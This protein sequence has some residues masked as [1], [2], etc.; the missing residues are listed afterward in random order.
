MS[1]IDAATNTPWLITPD[2]L[3]VVLDAIQRES[4][5]PEL[6]RAIREDRAA[7]PSALALRSARPL[8]GARDVGMVG[9]VAVI[10]IVGPIVRRGDMFSE[11]SG[12]TALQGIATDVQAALA[13]PQVDA[14]LLSIDSPGG[15]VTGVSELATHILASRAAKPIWAYV[16]GMGASAAYWIGSA[17]ERVVLADTAAVGSIGVVLAVRDPAAG[18]ASSIEFV[19]SQSPRKRPN[20]TTEAGRQ[21]LQDLV[22]HTAEVFVSAVAAQRG[23]SEATVLADFGQGGVMVGRRAVEAGLADA[24]ST[25]DQTLTDLAQAA[26]ARRRQPYTGRSV[27]QED[28]MNLRQMFAAMFGGAQDAGLVAAEAPAEPT[29]PPAV[30]ASLMASATP[31]EEAPPATAVAAAE[32]RAV[33][34]ERRL[35][36]LSAVVA[37]VEARAAEAAAEARAAAVAAFVD[38]HIRASRALPAERGALTDLY[39][40]ALAAGPELAAKVEALLAARPPHGLLGGERLADTAPLGVLPADRD[41]APADP[42]ARADAILATT[43]EGRAV[44]AARAK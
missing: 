31:A 40:S 36:E 44:L 27:A 16:E 21:A 35:Q 7:R 13:S 14:L 25:F 10:P 2:A 24:V 20:P 18:K 23:V 1:L 17:A 4:L 37:T 39:A 43:P 9:G 26:D 42:Q 30:A 5:D 38:G 8:D 19:S 41:G 12:L 29:P 11:V 15:E 28:P 6:A 3:R 34:A 33:E 22:D 32:A